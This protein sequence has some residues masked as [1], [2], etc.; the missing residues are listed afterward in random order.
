MTLLNEITLPGTGDDDLTGVFQTSH[1]RDDLRLSGFDVCP[2]DGAEQFELFVE[3]LGRSLRHVAGYGFLDLGGDALHRQC[4]LLGV[5]LLDDLLNE[6]VLEGRDVLEDEH[7]GPNLLGEVGIDAGQPLQNRLL[8][9]AVRVVQNLSEILDATL[10]LDLG[11]ADGAEALS[12]CRLDPADHVGGRA[13]HG[14]DAERDFGLELVVESA[15]DAE[16]V[17]NLT[18]LIEILLILNLKR[19]VPS[20]K[21]L[22]LCNG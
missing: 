12:Q 21:V 6:L 18:H 20:Q 14:P 17:R 7:Q 15:E 11:L 3:G 16:P 9:G 22:L 1:D 4:E 5:H 13:A 8:G 2:A 19:D 10:D